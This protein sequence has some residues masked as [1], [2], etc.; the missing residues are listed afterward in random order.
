MKDQDDF[1][2]GIWQL[3]LCHRQLQGVQIWS[4]CVLLALPPTC[5][6]ACP[7]AVVFFQVNRT[8]Y[9]LEPLEMLLSGWHIVYRAAHLRAERGM[10]LE[11]AATWEYNHEPKA[12]AAMK[13]YHWVKQCIPSSCS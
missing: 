9:L 10:C 4:G 7:L 5:C 3:V 13:L 6:P 8:T 2:A 11:P 12:P 1:L